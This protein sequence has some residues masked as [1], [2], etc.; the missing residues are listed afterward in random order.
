MIRVMLL[1]V[2][3]LIVIVALGFV[4]RGFFVG[5]TPTGAII[6]LALAVVYIASGLW[7][8]LSLEQGGV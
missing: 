8:R 6:M 7:R 3:A 2:P 4:I 1:V 5:S